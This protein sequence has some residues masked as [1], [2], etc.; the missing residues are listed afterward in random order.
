MKG[1]AGMEEKN[2]GNVKDELSQVGNLSVNRTRT[3]KIF[4]FIACFI[5]AFFIWYYAADH[6]TAI[7]DESFSSVPVEI[8][9]DSGFSVL[10]GNGVTVDVTVSGKRNVLKK[11][12]KQDI[13]AFIDMSSVTAAG[14]YKFDLQYELPNGVTL[15]KS[16]S[17]SISVYCDNTS[18]VTVPVRVA[19]PANYQIDHNYEMG[20]ADITTDVTEVIVTGPESVV[21]TIEAALLRV[22]LGNRVVDSTFTYSGSIVLVNEK[23][24]EITNSYVKTNV[25]GVTADIPVYKYRDVPITVK[26][27]Y[28]YFN[29]ENVAVKAEPS[30]V[31]VK[32][33]ADAVDSVTLEF[34]LDEKKINADTSYTM[35]IS[36]PD[37]VKNVDS[38]KTA[39]VSVEL[40]GISSKTVSVYNISV[41]NPDGLTYEPVTGPINIIVRGDSVLLGRL[42][43]M[44][45]TAVVDLSFSGEVS[46]AVMVPVT[47]VFSAPFEGKVYEVGSY[48][49]SVRIGVSD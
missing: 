34:E 43:S 6:D 7:F 48:S 32:G 28:G 44:N 42:S 40:K 11:L 3:E 41:T 10:S 1:D 39:V 12:T 19:Q 15:A 45:V 8:V 21:T 22:D 37:G 35:S 4:A 5:A 49:V 9:N 23:G 30:T 38:V 29:S 17:D 26:Y 31:R 14:R 27:R 25:S 13:R 36:L 16:S 46:G 2:T 47:F 20:T 24:E 33:E 18:T